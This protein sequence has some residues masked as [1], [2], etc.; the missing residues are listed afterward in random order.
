M[1]SRE[2]ADHHGHCSVSK[3][4]KQQQQPQQQQQLRC[5]K[6]RSES[7][8]VV[9]G[10]MFLFLRVESESK[11][12][13]RLLWSSCDLGQVTM[14]KNKPHWFLVP[15]KIREGGDG[16]SAAVATTLL[17]ENEGI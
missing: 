12:V 10:R 16:T 13:I 14:Y 2:P 6:H 9:F 8:K 17:L 1:T 5:F 7:E 4:H 3:K 11:C 15:P